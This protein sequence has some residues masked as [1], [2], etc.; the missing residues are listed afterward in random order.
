MNKLTEDEIFD[1]LKDIIIKVVEDSSGTNIEN[2][3]EVAAGMSDCVRGVFAGGD[4]SPAQFSEID[5]F[6]IATQG[7]AVDFGDLPY[8]NQQ[9]AGCSNGHGGL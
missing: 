4:G 5:Y 7:D 3:E 9:C 8:D 6:N 1:T 2:I